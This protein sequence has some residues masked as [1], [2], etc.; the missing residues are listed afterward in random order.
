MIQNKANIYIPTPHLL[1]VFHSKSPKRSPSSY[2]K[3][4]EENIIANVN[5]HQAKNINKKNVVKIG[6]KSTYFSSVMK[7]AVAAIIFEANFILSYKQYISI[8][9]NNDKHHKITAHKK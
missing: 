4:P 8:K 3:S 7:S 1:Q 9:N 2:H 6:T 5:I